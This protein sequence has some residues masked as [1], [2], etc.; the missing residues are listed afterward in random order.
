[1]QVDC[2]RQGLSELLNINMNLFIDLPHFVSFP[3]GTSSMAVTQWKVPTRKFPCGSN[4]TSWSAT[5]AVPL[6]G[7]TE[8]AQLPQH[9]STLAGHQFNSCLWFPVS[10]CSLEGTRTW[11]IFCSLVLTSPSALYFIIILYWDLASVEVQV[12]FML[13]PFRNITFR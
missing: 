2:S 3:T 7:S 1:M 4:Q 5:L 10:A 6:T 12:W 13:I 11:Q 9:S 8:L